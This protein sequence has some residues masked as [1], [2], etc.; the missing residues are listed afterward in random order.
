MGIYGRRHKADF[1]RPGPLYKP[2]QSG[3]RV[4]AAMEGWGMNNVL[5]QPVE[6]SEVVASFVFLASSKASL[7][8]EFPYIYSS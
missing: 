8:C 5:I 2:V 3:S 7:Y 1:G 4:A 6:P